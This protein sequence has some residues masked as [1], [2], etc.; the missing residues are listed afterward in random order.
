MVPHADRAMAERLYLQM[1]RIREFEER[2]NVL[3]LAGHIPGTIHL[4][5]GQ[6]ACAAGACDALKERDWVTITHR[7]HG[8]A[9]A[10]GVSAGSL[11]AELF[12]REGGCCRGFGGS[13][14]VGDISVGAV[15]A[16]AI[17]GASVP[18]SA[19][20]A[21]AFKTAGEGRVSLCFTGDGAVGEGDWHEGMNLAAVW[22]LPVIYLCENNQYS[23]S[24]RVDRMY[25]NDD[26]AARA[27]SYGI[28]SITIDGNNPFAVR[29][30]VKEEVDRIR[31]GDGGPAFIEC[32]TYRQGGHKR[33]D[34]GTYRPREEVDLWLARDP[35][36]RMER[37]IRREF[38]DS[39][40]DGIAADV[41]AEIDTAVEFAMASPKATGAI[42]S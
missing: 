15:P 22:Q 23:I 38:G 1:L 2:V 27:A 5:L 12:A 29:A 18:I 41:T 32:L 7:G 42:A 33:D 19:G 35:V 14:H 21:H 10:K 6:E 28:R 13:L 11:M 39:V 36:L 8:Q 24:T 17:V 20:I 26:L 3:F 31:G 37:A 16:I 34:P 30:A 4:S 25:R 9:L 40:A